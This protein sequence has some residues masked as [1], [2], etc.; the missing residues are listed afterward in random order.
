MTTAG[1]PYFERER[2]RHVDGTAIFVTPD[3]AA[4]QAEVAQ[5][6]GR[7][8]RCDFRPFGL[9]APVDWYAVRDERV[10]AVA[11][12]KRRSTSRTHYPTVFLS[13]RKWLALQLAGIGLGVPALFVVQFVD[14]LCYTPVPLRGT[15]SIAG[16]I[17]RVRARNDVEPVIEIPSGDFLPVADLPV[18][19]A[20]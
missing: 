15:V 9:L 2:A 4:V 7:R 14:Q 18:A 1:D 20:P 16:G 3:D 8:W 19:T 5:T 10:V 17:R 13:V 12:F 6:L 11:E